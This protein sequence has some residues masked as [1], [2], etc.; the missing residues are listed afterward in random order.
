MCATSAA[1]AD[2]AHNAGALLAVDNCFAAPALQRPVE[3]GADLIMHSGTKYL[4][5]QG[6]VMAGAMCG[7]KQ[8]GQRV[9]AR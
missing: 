2:I 6:R 7:P 3:L 1:L 8:D 4:D 5:G 9:F